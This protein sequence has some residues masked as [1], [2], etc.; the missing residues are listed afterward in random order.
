MED[1]RTEL[2]LVEPKSD[3]SY[4]VVSIPASIVAMLTRHRAQQNRERLIAGSRWKQTGHAFTSTIGTPLD[5]RNVRREFYALLKANNL[6]RLRPHDL[7]HSY[8]TF[9]LAAAEHPR[10]VQEILGHSS[11]QLTLDTCSA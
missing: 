11:V 4:R 2:Q 9:L 10:V 7:R 6:P 1:G 3:R 5:E 8:A